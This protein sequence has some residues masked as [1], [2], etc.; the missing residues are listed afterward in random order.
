MTHWNLIDCNVVA[1]EA[2]SKTREPIYPDNRLFFRNFKQAMEDD[3]H[4]KARGNKVLTQSLYEKLSR[5]YPLPRGLA[6]WTRVELLPQGR[7]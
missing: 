3:S 2:I 4:D 6:A 1:L 5:Y 7:N